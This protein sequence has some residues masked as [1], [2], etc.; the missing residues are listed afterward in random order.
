MSHTVARQCVRK[1]CSFRF[2]GPNRDEFACPKCGS[3][4][5]IAATYPTQILDENRYNNIPLSA[6]EIGLDNLRSALNVGSVFRTSDGAGVQHIHLFGICPPP[7]HPEVRKTA[8]GADDTIPWSQHWDGVE[9]V[10]NIKSRWSHHLVI[11]KNQPIG[12]S[13]LSSIS[14]E[15]PENDLDPG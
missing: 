5:S 11:G 2:P 8:L 10:R 1:A 12:G 14:I 9:A 7:T 13:F 3:A 4:T 15:K 6:L